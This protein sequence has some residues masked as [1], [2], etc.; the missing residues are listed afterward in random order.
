MPKYDN[1]RKTWQY[2]NEFKVKAV[3]LSLTTGIQVQEVANML[4]IHAFTIAERK[5]R[6]RKAYGWERVAP[7]NKLNGG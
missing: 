3:H 1:S 7:L 6:A 4:D 5:N 2:S